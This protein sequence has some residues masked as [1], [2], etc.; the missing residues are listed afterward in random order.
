MGERIALRKNKNLIKSIVLFSWDLL[1]T[2]D[3]KMRCLWT[4][5]PND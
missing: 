4:L 3:M 2:H 5:A 1:N